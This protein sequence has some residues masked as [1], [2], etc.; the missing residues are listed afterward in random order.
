MKIRIFCTQKKIPL[1][2]S[3]IEKTALALLKSEGI[4]AELIL[5]FVGKKRI[6]SLHE[7]F[8][9]DPSLTDCI[10]FPIDKEP[11]IEILGEIFICPQVA[12]KVHSLHKT[13]LEEELT[14]YLVH[15]VLHLLGFDDIKESDQKKMRK[16]EQLCMQFLQKKNLGIR[17]ANS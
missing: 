7:K 2:F 13:T 6:C 3:S 4:D 17:L 8:F 12:K 9:S 11:P 16:K 10:T 15:G 1:D 14:L 5:H